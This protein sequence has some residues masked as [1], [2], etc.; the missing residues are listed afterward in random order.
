M[1]YH[2]VNLLCLAVELDSLTAF[3][4]ASGESFLVFYGRCAAYFSEYSLSNF[5]YTVEC[6]GPCNKHNFAPV[7]PSLG[8]PA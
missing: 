4:V 1:G 8:W 6:L 2:G 3:F 7:G 5:H